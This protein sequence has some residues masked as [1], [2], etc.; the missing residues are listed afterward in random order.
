[1][2]AAVFGLEALLAAPPPA[3]GKL[4]FDP[5]VEIHDTDVVYG[6]D[7]APVTVVE[8]ASLTCVHCARFHRESLPD[9]LKG[10]VDTGKARLVLR[11]FPLDGSALRAAGAVS[12]LD[13]QYRPGAV[14][15]LMKNQN[16]W[17]SASDPAAESIGI[18]P[19][20][21]SVKSRARACAA[22]GATMEKLMEPAAQ[23]RSAGISATPSF[24]I[25][26]KVYPGFMSAEKL[27]ALVDAVR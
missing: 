2:A 14:A 27:G 25:A 11:H 23:A 5:A 8:Y 1:M 20:G 24:V 18:L 9:F 19:L 26:G 16:R 3:S 21:E 4:S 10:W 15:L 17:A 22:E 12:C 7:D 13:A 6:S